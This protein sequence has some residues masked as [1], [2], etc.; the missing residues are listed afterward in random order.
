MSSQVV[1]HN[2]VQRVEQDVSQLR[3]AFPELTLRE[4][5]RRLQEIESEIE[6]LRGDIGFLEASQSQKMGGAYATLLALK[7]RL[8]QKE[9]GNLL[10]GCDLVL[11]SGRAY[12]DERG[13]APGSIIVGKALVGMLEGTL[14]SQEAVDRV[15]RKGSNLYDK[16]AYGQSLG[17]HLPWEE[18]VVFFGK[19]LSPKGGVMESS[20]TVGGERAAYL[21]VLRQLREQVEGKPIGALLKV[22]QDYFGVMVGAGDI[23]LFDPNGKVAPALMIKTDSIEKAADILASRRGATQRETMTYYPVESKV[24]GDLAIA[25]PAQFPDIPLTPTQ[26]F[27]PV[28]TGTNRSDVVRLIRELERVGPEEVEAVLS[29][30][31]TVKLSRK[32]DTGVDI[33]A[34]V[35]ALKAELYF[36]EAELLAPSDVEEGEL[37]DEEDVVFY[38]CEDAFPETR[39]L[40]LAQKRE[41]TA[42]ASEVGTLFIR[43]H[44]LP[45]IVKEEAVD[46]TAII[47]NVEMWFQS[48]LPTLFFGEGVEGKTNLALATSSLHSVTAFLKDYNTAR[49]AV[50]GTR[51]GWRCRRR[52][53]SPAE[54]NTRIHDQMTHGKESE[55][56][57]L[58]TFC[59]HLVDLFEAKQGKQ[60]SGPLKGRLQDHTAAVLNALIDTVLSPEFAK[61]MVL[62][63]IHDDQMSEELKSLPEREEGTPGEVPQD[64]HHEVTAFVNELIDFGSPRYSSWI[65]SSMLKT[66][67]VQTDHPGVT[68]SVLRFGMRMLSKPL[69]RD[70]IGAFLRQAFSL[71]THQAAQSEQWVAT[72]TVAVGALRRYG[73]DD[74]G[75]SLK[76]RVQEVAD[77]PQALFQKISGLAREMGSRKTGALLSVTSWV[78]P[79]VHTFGQDLAGN[80]YGLSQSKPL[81]RTLT[82]RYLIQGT[83]I[84]EVRT[85]LGA[86]VIPPA[87]PIAPQGPQDLSME[88]G[89]QM[90]NLLGNYLE[91]YV[92]E[93]YLKETPLVT[94]VVDLSVVMVKNFLPEMIGKPQ[95][96]TLPKAK[97]Q[98]IVD[99]YGSVGSFIHDYALAVQ[100]AK[101][102]EAFEVYASEGREEVLVL[103]ALERV[104][105]KPLRISDQDVQKKLEAMTDIIVRSHCKGISPVQAQ[106]VRSTSFVI[107]KVVKAAVD[108]L[109]SPEMM[110][111]LV[112]GMI[113]DHQGPPLEDP[114]HQYQ[115]WDQEVLMRWN[116]S[117]FNLMKGVVQLGEPSGK[118]EAVI[119]SILGISN[120]AQQNLGS[121]LARFSAGPSPFMA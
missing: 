27:E 113:Q 76:G 24:V 98:M 42:R 66:H 43:D 85:Q 88:A 19:S 79:S 121:L 32:L 70:E 65:A 64:L 74:T 53:L 110:C 94:S 72:A 63:F 90:S 44:V 30:Y 57:I 117:L 105:G 97:Q 107:P 68:K 46:Q 11:A 21:D 25:A 116:D 5:R 10:A 77:I 111:A 89:R 59:G 35:L 50:E 28:L 91:T 120:G 47:E 17:A 52:T 14:N 29:R 6:G 86:C 99:V 115:S 80:L 40:R 33:K 73:W 56:A 93:L 45:Q 92:G 75:K 81:M 108:L 8:E 18:T 13:T 4:A 95:Q 15:L 83:L 23:C 102:D 104:R 101:K 84:P 109:F 41:L 69:F 3:E 114:H 96:G 71:Q 118:M 78:M 20:L 1:S 61:M 22:G 67:F 36:H 87:P 60:I 103:G 82:I 100:E 48:F 2:F 51:G 7:E 9:L 106:L 26:E 112:V 54:L 12:G 16:L 39:E 58:K 37:S 49:G 34:A 38:D 119:Q 31:P 62:G 55:M